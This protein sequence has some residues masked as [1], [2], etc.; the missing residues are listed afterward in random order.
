M[1]LKQPAVRTSMLNIS[2][3]IEYH[4]HTAVV[5]E[6]DKQFLLSMPTI[7]SL[8]SSSFL[9]ARITVLPAIVS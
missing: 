9:N 2:T 5:I 8:D 4:A 1:Q 7:R 3:L 6:F